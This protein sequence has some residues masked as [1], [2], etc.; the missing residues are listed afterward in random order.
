MRGPDEGHPVV[1]SG[2]LVHSGSALN[3]HPVGRILFEGHR[4]NSEV[5]LEPFDERDNVQA[6][7]TLLPGT[8]E[9]RAYYAAHPQWESIDQEI[10]GLP[11]LGLVGSPLARPR[12]HPFRLCPS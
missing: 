8:E 6:R 12:A 7:N 9:Y 11:G 2:V 5:P 1:P 4:R 10:R 3:R